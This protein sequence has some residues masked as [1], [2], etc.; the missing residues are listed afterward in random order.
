M[1][2]DTKK[3]VVFKVVLESP[4]FAWQLPCVSGTLCPN[5]SQIRPSVQFLRAFEVLRGTARGRCFA[6]LPI[7]IVQW[8]KVSRSII[9]GGVGTYVYIYI[10][11]A[12]LFFYFL[13]QYIAGLA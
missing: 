3:G 10:F 7:G 1:R 11:F 8:P 9:Q 12:L 13:A 6:T 5:L 4:N 2:L